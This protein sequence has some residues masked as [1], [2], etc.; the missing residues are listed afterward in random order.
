MHDL[1][2]SGNTEYDL[3][4]KNSDKSGHNVSNNNVVDQMEPTVKN[5]KAKLFRF[6]TFR[7]KKMGFSHL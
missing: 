2:S 6:I 4:N 1:G 3:E 5:V 7:R